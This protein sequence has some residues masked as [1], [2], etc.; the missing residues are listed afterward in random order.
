[1][2]VRETRRLL[3]ADQHI[4]AVFRIVHIALHLLS[5]GAAGVADRLFGRLVEVAYWISSRA[6]RKCLLRV[7]SRNIWLL[8][9]T[10][11]PDVADCKCRPLTGD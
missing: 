10:V 6:F 5:W 2:H 3:P 11:S 7:T 9:R 8:G 1:M 4:T